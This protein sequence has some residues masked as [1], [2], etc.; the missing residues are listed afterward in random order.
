MDDARRFLRFVLPGLGSVVQF[1][2]FLWVLRPSQLAHFLMDTQFTEKSGLGLAVAVFVASGGLGFILS[3]LYHFIYWLPLFDR[4]A[5]NHRQVLIEADKAHILTLVNPKKANPH[6][7]EPLDTNKLS[8]ADAWRISTALWFGRIGE[9]KRLEGALARTDTLTSILHS[10][11]TLIFGTIVSTLGGLA[12]AAY[13][14][15]REPSPVTYLRIIAFFLVWIFLL[16]AQCCSFQNAV[17]HTQR[18][19]D[20]ILF[21]DLR[22]S[23]EETKQALVWRVLL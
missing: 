14:V 9:S 3:T 17:R 15:L 2:F 5:I 4:F 20:M 21:E 1:L 10:L 8:R 6:E 16:V 18:V 13:L 22:R 12:V 7:E 23:K 19:I 11:G